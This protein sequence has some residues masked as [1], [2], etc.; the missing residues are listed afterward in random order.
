MCSILSKQIKQLYGLCGPYSLN[1]LEIKMI[2]YTALA[3]TYFYL[4]YVLILTLYETY[5]S[6]RPQ[7]NGEQN[8]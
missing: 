6:D 2:I 7:P 8:V 3:L 1:Q 4:L 5:R